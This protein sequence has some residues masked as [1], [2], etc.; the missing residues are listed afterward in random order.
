MSLLQVVRLVPPPTYCE[1]RV[2]RS[3]PVLPPAGAITGW[4]DEL[5]FAALAVAYTAWGGIARGDDLGRLLA[6][7]GPT[8]FISMAKLLE[9]EEIFGFEWQRS[10]WIPMFQ[11]RARDLSLRPEPRQVRA[12]LGADF[13]GW[14][15]SAWFVEPNE[16]LA[17]RR[18]ID[19]L[20]SDLDAVLLAA[21]A[22][23]FVAAG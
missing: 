14:T 12:E 10:P 2:E 9:D 22:D 7:H 15:A 23:R 19:L 17:R 18:P 1:G 20:E 21:Q 6:D 4:Q 16:W 8:T 11:F 3:L 5:A 13:D